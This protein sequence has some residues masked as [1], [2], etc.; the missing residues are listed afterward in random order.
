MLTKLCENWHLS[1]DPLD[2]LSNDVYDYV[3]DDA[4]GAGARWGTRELGLLRQQGP[5][6]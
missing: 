2:R 4:L 3:T 6:R 1:M 5:A